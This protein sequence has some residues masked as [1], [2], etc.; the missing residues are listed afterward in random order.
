MIEDWNPNSIP[1]LKTTCQRYI[2]NFVRIQLARGEITPY[3]Q[4]PLALKHGQGTN[5]TQKQKPNFNQK[6]NKP[7]NRC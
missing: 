1:D 2:S 3:G 7:I 4:Q 5:S 6:Q